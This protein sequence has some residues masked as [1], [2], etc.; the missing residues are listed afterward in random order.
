M[1]MTVYYNIP[2]NPP[3]NA[4]EIPIA[5]RSTAPSLAR[6]GAQQVLQALRYSI[7]QRKDGALQHVAGA[8]HGETGPARR[9]QGLYK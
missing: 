2:L 6:Q 9:T 5:W 4:H 8:L 3:L 1:P 7:A